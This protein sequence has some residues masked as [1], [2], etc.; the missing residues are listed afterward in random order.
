MANVACR[1]NADTNVRFREIYLGSTVIADAVA[2]ELGVK[3]ASELA[4]I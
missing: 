2:D 4:I 1:D 3:E